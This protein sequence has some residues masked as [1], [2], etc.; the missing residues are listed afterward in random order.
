MTAPSRICQQGQHMV[1]SHA[2]KVM[3][4]VP[5][6]LVLGCKTQNLA[7][8]QN[9]AYSQMFTGASECAQWLKR[10]PHLWEQ[11]RKN[12]KT[13]SCSPPHHTLNKG[14]IVFIKQHPNHKSVYG[15]LHNK[16]AVS[17]G[18]RAEK[19]GKDMPVWTAAWRITFWLQVGVLEQQLTDQHLWNEKSILTLSNS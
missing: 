19:E 15:Q 1:S 4:L 18:N 6:F 13:V 17:M 14:T 16:R 10:M 9:F 2:P 12:L 11:D 8:T 3:F 7:L 5:S